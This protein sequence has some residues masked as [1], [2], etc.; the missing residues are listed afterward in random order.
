MRIIKFRGIAE[1][2]VE[3]T[4]KEGD[5][6]Y[7]NLIVNNGHPFIVGEVAD[8]DNEYL[9]LEFWVGVKPESVGQFTGLL[10]KNGKEIYEGDLLKVSEGMQDAIGEPEIVFV[11]WDKGGFMTSAYRYIWLVAETSEVIGNIYE[12]PDLLSSTKE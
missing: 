6:V 12:N 8:A 10:D 1:E 11:I 7:G 4:C 2:T 5:Y 9:A 3:E